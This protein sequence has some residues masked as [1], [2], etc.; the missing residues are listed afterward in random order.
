MQVELSLG[1][2]SSARLGECFLQEEF[3][4]FWGFFWFILKV[5]FKLEVFKDI[6]YLVSKM[7]GTQD[8]IFLS[9]D[10][11]LSSGIKSLLWALDVLVVFSQ[12]A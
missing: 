1:W 10:L 4:V 3:G 6:V 12:A 2:R 9:S 7:R 11:E 8:H 5:N